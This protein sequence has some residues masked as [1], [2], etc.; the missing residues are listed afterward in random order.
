[1]PC[2]ER[3]RLLK[4]YEVAAGTGAPYPR[5][6][7]GVPQSFADVL[8]AEQLDRTLHEKSAALD[9]HDKTHGCNVTATKK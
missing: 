4:E 7:K 5:S 8:H 6:M 2:E 9:E 3:N 1:M